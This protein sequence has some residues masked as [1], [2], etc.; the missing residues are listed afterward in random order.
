M[1]PWKAD[2]NTIGDPD[3]DW[4]VYEFQWTPDY[5]SWL[6]NGKEIRK[7]EKSSNNPEIEYMTRK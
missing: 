1:S 2:R 5:I 3:D 6:Y 7:V 4:G